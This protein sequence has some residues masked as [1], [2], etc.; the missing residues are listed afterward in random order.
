MYGL[1]EQEINF[2]CLKASKHD[3]K[4]TTFDFNYLSLI[5]ER[6]RMSGN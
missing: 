3:R 6:N 4:A 2:Q 1:R 5:R